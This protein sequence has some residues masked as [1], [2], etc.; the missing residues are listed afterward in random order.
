MTRTLAITTLCV[1][2]DPHERRHASTP[3]TLDPVPLP[4][5][6]G[7]ADSEAGARIGGGF[8]GEEHTDQRSRPRYVSRRQATFAYFYPPHTHHL[9]GNALIIR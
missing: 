3:P 8:W 7:V 1:K 5:T 2:H 9:N 4:V 6:E